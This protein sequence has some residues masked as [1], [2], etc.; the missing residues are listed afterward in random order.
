M[1][2]RKNAERN[3]TLKIHENHFC[4]IWKSDV[5]SF[6]KAIKELKD[7][8]EVVDFLISDK[9]VKILLNRNKNLK[10]LNL[11]WLTWLFMI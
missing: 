8:F 10:K 3:T 5:F 9:H 7:N 6:D 4:W 2:P 11:N 1:C